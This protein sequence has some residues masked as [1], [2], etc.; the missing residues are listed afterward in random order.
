MHFTYQKD[1][2]REFLRQGDVLERTKEINE[3]LEKIHPHFFDN[4]KNI[5]FMVLTQSCDLV[6]RCGDGSNCKAT[7][8][9]ITPVRSLDSVLRK[10]LSQQGFLEVEAELPVMTNKAK[11]KATEFLFRLFNNNEPGYF[12][13]ESEDTALTE[14]CVAILSLSVAIKADLHYDTC[15]AAKVLELDDTFQAKLGWLVGQMY[16]RVGTLDWDTN[17]IKIK[18]KGLLEN[19]AIWVDDDKIKALE[20]GFKT[21]HDSNPERKMTKRD[22]VSIIKGVPTLKKQVL[23]QVETLVLGVFGKNEGDK[24]AKLSKRLADD[25]FL[26]KLLN[27]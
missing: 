10:S 17:K 18:S 25:P 20:I 4:S 21:F 27:K 2:S 23:E 26:S 14:D 3:L 7:Y 24:V 12:Y 22:I 5:Y 19:A 16:S 6:R 11:G 8:I 15:L 9:T 1:I 13:L